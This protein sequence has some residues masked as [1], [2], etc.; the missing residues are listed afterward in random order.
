MGEEIRVCVIHSALP[1]KDGAKRCRDGWVPE[2]PVC[3]FR[4]YVLAAGEKKSLVA[5]ITDILASQNRTTTL[6]D[7]GETTLA[8]SSPA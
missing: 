5:E 3:R 7:K 4:S 2:F 8:E 1:Y 6:T